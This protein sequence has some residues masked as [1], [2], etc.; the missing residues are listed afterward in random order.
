[1]TGQELRKEILEAGVRLWQVAEA[2]GLS[3]FTFSR[4]LRHNFSDEETK[5]ILEA[6]AELKARK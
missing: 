1:M 3:E 5:H 6:V 2:I 4:K